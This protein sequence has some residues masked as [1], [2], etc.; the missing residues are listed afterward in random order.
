MSE[1]LPDFGKLV[2]RL[3]YTR[4]IIGI[5]TGIHASLGSSEVWGD[6]KAAINFQVGEDSD[7]RVFR[8]VTNQYFVEKSEYISRI[9]HNDREVVENTELLLQFPTSQ[10]YRIPATGTARMDRQLE[11]C[12]ALREETSLYLTHYM[13]PYKGKFH[14]KMARALVNIVHPT[15]HGTVMD[16]FAGSGTLLVEA[17]VMGIR[18]I[19]V[20]INP[21]AVL[22]SNVKTQCLKIRS[23]ELRDAIDA[24][25]ALVS[26]AVGQHKNISSGHVEADPI[27]DFSK[28]DRMIKAVPPGIAR[29]LASPHDTLPKIAIATVGL[30]LFVDGAVRDFL[31]LSL[32]GAISDA[33]RRTNA[34]FVI[35][36]SRRLTDLWLIVFLFEYMS[37][38][39]HMPLADGICIPGDARDM[40]A[41]ATGSIDS[42][43]CS[44]PYSTALDYI[45]NDETQLQ[46]LGLADTLGQLEEA[47]I[48]N[49]LYEGRTGSDSDGT[50]PATR[51]KALPPYAVNVART[52]RER[53]R[54]DAAVRCLKFFGDM[55]RAL[56]EMHRVLKPGGLAA[57]VIGNNHF[58]AGRTMIEVTN[59]DVVRRLAQR[60]GFRTEEVVRRVLEK[61]GTGMIQRESILL[62]KSYVPTP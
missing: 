4:E 22:M 30:R 43:V 54:P 59:D 55:D 5:A 56:A 50:M 47:M 13:H 37:S 33:V 31:R 17:A 28:V 16:N 11:D 35:V 48:G 10:L 58:R 34:D 44:P 6:G 60:N 9:S 23:L 41:V 29:R 1:D 15:E 42:I 20:E 3:A 12:L 38:F 24:Y 7:C 49:P 27:I 61:T 39:L 51:V 40:T 14:P 18:S 45:R 62:L 32:S 36:L 19:G 8:F 53:G 25:L 21:L 2:R 57:V 52:L 26:R 46:L